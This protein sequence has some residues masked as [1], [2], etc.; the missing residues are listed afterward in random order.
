MRLLRESDP[1]IYTPKRLSEM[2]NINRNTVAKLTKAP[3]HK[4]NEL[5]K[6]EQSVTKEVQQEKKT[7]LENWIKKNQQR[8]HKVYFSRKVKGM[9]GHILR[10]YRIAL[11]RRSRDVRIAR[12]QKYGKELSKNPPRGPEAY[13]IPATRAKKLANM[14][15]PPTIVQGF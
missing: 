1:V 5:I 6:A 14:D 15:V 3:T 7:R 8:E 12:K 4:R 9:S 11:Q 2:F 13:T 10:D